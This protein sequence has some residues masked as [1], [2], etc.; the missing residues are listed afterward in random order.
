MSDFTDT[1]AIEVESEARGLRKQLEQELQARKEAE[2]RATKVE[3]EL[4]FAKAGI[5]L[6]DPRMSYFVKGYEGDSDPE[7][8]R[9][10]ALEAGFL[11]T[12]TPDVP[13]DELAQHEK[14][15]SLSA[16]TQTIDFDVDAEYVQ[17]LAQARTKDDV[18]ALM[19]KFG[20][21]RTS[22]I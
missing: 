1:D 12:P 22:F 16:G 7:K 3:R 21:P 19:D 15:A 4:A 11:S 17:A 6:G 13:S 2:S 9:Q 10:A 8:I 18:L 14:A 20:S 5:D